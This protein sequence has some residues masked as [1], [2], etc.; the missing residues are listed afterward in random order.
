MRLDEILNA[1][2][3][4]KVVCEATELCRDLEGECDATSDGASGLD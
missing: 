3:L 4:C 1:V 2:G